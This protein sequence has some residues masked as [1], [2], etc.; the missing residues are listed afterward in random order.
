MSGT[1]VPAQSALRGGVSESPYAEKRERDPGQAGRGQRAWPPRASWPAWPPI[2]VPPGSRGDGPRLQAACWALGGG[3]RL[4]QERGSGH[5]RGAG[6][7]LSCGT[8]TPCTRMHTQAHACTCRHRCIHIHTCTCTRTQPAHTCTCTHTH[9]PRHTHVHTCTCRHTCTHIHTLHTH[10]LVLTHTPRHTHVHTC[11]CRH[12]CTNIHTCARAHPTHTCTRMHMQAH[13]YT[14][15]LLAL[16]TV[17][18]ELRNLTSIRLF[19]ALLALAP[20]DSW[21]TQLDFWSQRLHPV[22]NVVIP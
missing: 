20:R 16:P 19:P 8:H 15:L 14:W 4:R 13:A 12:T 1:P 7:M 10:A 5:Y 22:F 18:L 9:T 11:I 21:G 3:L 2:Q 17:W 6:G